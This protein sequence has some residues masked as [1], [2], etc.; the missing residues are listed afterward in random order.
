MQTTDYTITRLTFIILY[1]S[2]IT[3]FFLKL[4]LIERLKKVAA[5]I[6]KKIRFN[7]YNPFN[8]CFY[9]FLINLKKIFNPLF[10]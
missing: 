2:R 7:Y 3:Y 5:P 1:K 10:F 4:I 8:G 9:D 6:F